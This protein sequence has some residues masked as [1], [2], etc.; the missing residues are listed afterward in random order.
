MG[1]WRWFD[2]KMM[3]DDAD[4]QRLLADIAAYKTRIHVAQRQLHD[5]QHGVPE[6]KC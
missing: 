6:E 1:L 2:E 5:L 4:Y 3:K